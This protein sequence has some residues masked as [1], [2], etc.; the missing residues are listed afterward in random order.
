MCID[1]RVREIESF[2]RYFLSIMGI[3]GFC[4]FVIFISLRNTLIF[5][6]C[7]VKPPTRHPVSSEGVTFFFLS[8]LFTINL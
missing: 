3:L 7:F 6:S 8:F 4:D 5:Q 2:M 1:V